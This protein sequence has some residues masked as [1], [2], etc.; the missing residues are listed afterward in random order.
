MNPQPVINDLTIYDYGIP[1]HHLNRLGKLKCLYMFFLI[2][3]IALVGLETFLVLSMFNI[4]SL[5][6]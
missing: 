4:F 5:L 2:F 3:N 6:F 1:Q